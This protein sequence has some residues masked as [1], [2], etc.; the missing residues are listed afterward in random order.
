MENSIRNYV[1]E[2]QRTLDLLPMQSI[3][4]VVQVLHTARLRQQQVFVFG[5]FNL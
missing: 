5:N 3:N 4:D 1:V 2:L